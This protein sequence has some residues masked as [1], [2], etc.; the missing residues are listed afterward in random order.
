MIVA[1]V[2]DI[3]EF[4]RLSEAHNGVFGSK[5]WLQMYGAQLQV[6]GIYANDGQLIGGFHYLKT[7]RY[8]L[9]FIKLPPYTPHCGLFYK[10]QNSNPA[11]RNTTVKELTGL[12]ADY[13]LGLK[14]SL[15][16]LAFS[17][18]ETDMQAFIWKNFKVV[19]NYTYQINLEKSIEEIYAAFDSK[20][21]NT[22][23]KARKQDL[24]LQV[25]SL[26]NEQLFSF[27]SQSLEQTGANVYKKE[28]RSVFEATN[29]TASA[30]SFAALSGNTVV[31]L[32]YCVLDAETC[33]YLLGGTV[34]VN[35]V[36]GVNNLLLVS[37]IEEAKKRACK[38]FDFE[39]SMLIGVEKFFRA[40]GGELKPYYTVN[41][42]RKWLEILLKFI[43]PSVF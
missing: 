15:C 26:N 41:K 25:N 40:F 31:G 8:G 22:I 19:P 24:T 42:G 30:F 35:G 13:F 3:E 16:I 10:L 36:S 28:L 17:F 11:A 6:R 5:N 33:Y 29:G 32:V 14:S 12:V 1:A 37:A 27:F 4:F 2:N 23:A 34:K 9:T 38:V 20:N 18:R 21:R 43:K 7:K 39:G